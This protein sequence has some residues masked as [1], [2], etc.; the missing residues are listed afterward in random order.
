MSSLP[1]PSI[2]GAARSRHVEAQA[3]VYPGMVTIGAT[4]YTQGSVILGQA[5]IENKEGGQRNVQTLTWTIAKAALASAPA[6][7]SAI[8]YNGATWIIDAVAGQES[9]SKAWVIRAYHA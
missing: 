9:Y 6:V 1:P 2:V 3:A 4:S 8:T 5:T 7:L